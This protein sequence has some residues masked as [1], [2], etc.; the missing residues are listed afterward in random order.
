M[1]LRR[2]TLSIA[3]ALMAGCTTLPSDTQPVTPYPTVTPTSP[4]GVQ[5]ATP[6]PTVTPTSPRGAQ[7][8]TP[9]PTVTTTSV[10]QDSEA[11]VNAAR[12]RLTRGGLLNPD[13]VS[14]ISVT[15]TIFPDDCLGLPSGFT[16]HPIETLGYIIELEQIQERYVFYVDQEGKQARLARSSLEPLRDAFIEWQYNDGQECRVALIST[17]QIRHGICGEELLP[18]LSWGLRW[19]DIWDNI[20]GQS[21][22]DYLKQR[23]APFTAETIRGT[24]V[25]EGTGTVVASPAEQRAIAEWALERWREAEC[26]YLPAD[27]GLVLFWVEESPSLCGGLWVYQTGLAVAFNCPRTE[28]SGVGFLTA[29]QMEQ[30]YTWLDSGKRWNIER[31]GQV[32]G[33]PVRVI[34]DFPISDTGEEATAEDIERVLQFAREVYVGLTAG[35]PIGS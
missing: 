5:P 25:F 10:T 6:H 33:K 17:D 7:P 4:R 20:N 24:I 19:D 29:T 9:Y 15:P 35:D 11:A 21:Q 12:L 30:F 26:V 13:L 31:A 1:H 32:E 2:F 27:A 22:T 3:V 8:A 23:Y 14:V 18:S 34:L 16:C 28:V